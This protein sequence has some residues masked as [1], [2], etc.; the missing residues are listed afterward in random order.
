[1]KFNSAKEAIQWLVWVSDMGVMSAGS[2]ES[3]EDELGKFDVDM[4]SNTNVF[5]DCM[6][7]K[8][9]IENI[10]E[11]CFR[12]PWLQRIMLHY[13]VDGYEPTIDKWM[14]KISPFHGRMDR[15]RRRLVLDTHIHRLTDALLRHNYLRGDALE[16]HRKVEISA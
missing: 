1:M 4:S 9:D 3:D 15:R 6:L 12:E 2:F 16:Q 5:E 8:V 10:F 13:A 14:A 7:A 11:R